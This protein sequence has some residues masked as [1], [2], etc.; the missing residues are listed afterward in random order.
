MKQLLHLLSNKIVLKSF[1]KKVLDVQ[2]KKLFFEMW[3]DFIKSGWFAAS[4][5]AVLE[6]LT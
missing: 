1:K 2:N 5:K 4:L 6:T 3:V